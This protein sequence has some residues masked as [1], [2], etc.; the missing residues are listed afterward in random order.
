MSYNLKKIKKKY[1]SLGLKKSQ[2]LYITADFGKIIERNFLKP[3]VVED[4]FK[5]IKEIIGID[6]TII[7]PTATLNLCKTDKIFDPKKTPSFNM[8]FF[9][10]LIRKKGG[11]KRSLHPLWSVSAI[12]KLSNYFTKDISRHAFGY[13][14]IW[15]R[16]IKKN[17][18]SLHIGVN[19]R[20]SLSII[21]YTEL[22]SG[23]PY[24]FTKGFDQYI[25]RNGKK[26][27]EEFFHFCVKNEKKLIRDKN[28]KIYKNFLSKFKPK[29][30]SFDRG[31]IIIFPLKNFYKINLNY[32]SKN[33]YAWTKKVFK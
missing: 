29:K 27:K 6:G 8:G 7:V 19:P 26:V 32:L 22:V 4:H 21:H 3:E 10:E 17:A 13:D 28:V 15:T 14:S 16:L 30:I 20:Q 23:A 12:G 2:N 18:L 31:K 11:A 24:R 25:I 1:I 33:P 9:S 5:A